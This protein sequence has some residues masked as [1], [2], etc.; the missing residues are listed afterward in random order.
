VS[1]GECAGERTDLGNLA[2][3][4]SSF[5]AMLELM[6]ERVETAAR[7]RRTTVNGAEF[8][9]LV[10]GNAWVLKNEEFPDRITTVSVVRERDGA[11]SM[12]FDKNHPDTYHGADGTNNNLI[13]FITQGRTWF[14]AGNSNGTDAVGDAF[15][16][17]IR[18]DRATGIEAWR[19]WLQS[20]TPNVPACFLLQVGDFAVPSETTGGF[21]YF[22]RNA[23]GF[24]GWS[25]VGTWRVRWDLQDRELLRIRFDE[26][27]AEAPEADVFED[28]SLRRGH[29][30]VAIQQWH[31]AARTQFRRRISE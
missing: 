17:D 30:L 11:I 4:V 26:T 14:H 7:R 28:W 2:S 18:V 3:G 5:L 6:L 21:Q 13:W 8:F 23:A 31:D 15:P 12:H 20:L 24:E 25:A 19:I 10:P 16:D 29:G 9:Q 22:A 1:R 27:Y